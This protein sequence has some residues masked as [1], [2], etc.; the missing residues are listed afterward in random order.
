MAP[1]NHAVFLKPSSDS[2]NFYNTELKVLL[3]SR[4]QIGGEIEFIPAHRALLVYLS[5]LESHQ[6]TLIRECL[7]PKRKMGLVLMP[8]LTNTSQASLEIN[9]DP[10]ARAPVSQEPHRVTKSLSLQCVALCLHLLPSGGF[11]LLLFLLLLQYQIFLLV[12][13]QY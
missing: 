8:H 4:L 7:G 5:I 10:D 6:K 12:P 1:Y 9:T 11:S 13:T 2:D 3:G